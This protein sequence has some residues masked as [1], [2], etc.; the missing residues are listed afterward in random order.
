MKQVPYIS[1]Q[2]LLTCT[3]FIFRIYICKTFEDSKSYD[4]FIDAEFK[5][6]CVFGLVLIL[7][8]FHVD[9]WLGY[10]IFSV[11]ILHTIFAGMM[12][13]YRPIFGIIYSIIAVF[14]HFGVSPPF[15]EVPSIIATLTEDIFSA[16][17]ENVKNCIV[18][19]YTTWENRCIGVTP[20]FTKL[21]Q[22]Y[23]SEN[24][25]FARIDLGRAPN[26]CKQYQ[27][28]ITN[29]T[30]RQIPTIIRFKDGKEDSRLSPA[31]LGPKDL[32]KPT[33]AKF[34][35]LQSPNHKNV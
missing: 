5:G 27:I 33:I 2:L 7:R 21:A 12:V 4:T 23:S 26:I 9:S 28:S 19:F 8:I 24:L 22:E 16:Y 25:V 1:I 3:Y 13:F 11:K 31:V 34:F 15:F 17:V 20:V 18:L 14:I 10:A 32:N 6:L 35:K 29:G 30:L